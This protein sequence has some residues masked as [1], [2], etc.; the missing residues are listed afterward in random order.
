MALESSSSFKFNYSARSVWIKALFYKNKRMRKNKKMKMTLKFN[1]EELWDNF[2][3]FYTHT[4]FVCG[5]EMNFNWDDTEWIVTKDE[6]DCGVRSWLWNNKKLTLNHV[7]VLM[8]L[9]SVFTR[10]FIHIM[11][12]LL[13]LML[14]S[15]Y[16]TKYK[17][18]W[19]SLYMLQHLALFKNSS[20]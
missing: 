14:T 9:Y 19:V 12:L 16:E 4:F 5:H 17:C 7:H 2:L 3:F 8:L 20:S 11:L 13:L 15:V 18:K 1:F 10:S 6:V